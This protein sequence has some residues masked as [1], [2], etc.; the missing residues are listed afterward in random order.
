MIIKGTTDKL[1]IVLNERPTTE[2]GVVVA[3]KTITSTSVTPDRV[4][5]S[6]DGDTVVDLIS[7]IASGSYVQIERINVYNADS[8]S[9]T[10]TIQLYD[11]TNTVIVRSVTLNS[12]ETLLYSCDGWQITTGAN[13]QGVSIYPVKASDETAAADNPIIYGMTLAGRDILKMGQFDPIQEAIYAKP[14]VLWTPSTSGTW[15]GTSGNSLGSGAAVNPSTTNLYTLYRRNSWASVVTTLNQ[16]VG[17]RTD[18]QFY[19]GN[20][21]YRGGFFAVCMFGFQSWVAG[22]RLF[23][24][25]TPTTTTV[26]TVQPSTLANTFGFCIE[27]GDTAITLLHNDASG[28]GTKE[29]I[30]G[31]PALAT[32]NG[33]I[34]YIYCK[35]NDSVMYWRLDDILTKTKIGEGSITTDLPDNATAMNF[36]CIMSNGANTVAGN[37]NIGVGL[38]YIR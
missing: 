19:R 24:G 38:I 9:F 16:Q 3:Y 31:Q 8:L 21:A 34:A 12:G 5:D 25:F 36:Q 26:V 11:G 22:D 4:I 37:A 33:Y 18:N 23:V 29:T 1:Q 28:T 2:M 27:A 10:V 20:A 30:T 32:N 15:L 17:I 14:M 6:T 35:P 13:T 7:G